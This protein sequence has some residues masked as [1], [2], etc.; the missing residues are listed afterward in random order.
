MDCLRN[1]N[2]SKRNEGIRKQE[3][4]ENDFVEE[5]K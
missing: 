4:R 2:Y 5:P 1:L 3:F